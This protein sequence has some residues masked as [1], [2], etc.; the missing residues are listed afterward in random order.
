MK[1]ISTADLAACSYL[2]LVPS[3]TNANC[4]KELKQHNSCK[5][6]LMLESEINHDASHQVFTISTVNR[7]RRSMA[8]DARFEA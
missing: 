2:C 5:A 6:Q 4:Q 7:A 3:S 8:E 1:T